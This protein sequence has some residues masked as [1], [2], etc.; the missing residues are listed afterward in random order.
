MEKRWRRGPAD[1]R[2][3]KRRRRLDNWIGR[4]GVGCDPLVAYP[5]RRDTFDLPKTV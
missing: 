4:E 1:L 5:S 3:Y 2:V